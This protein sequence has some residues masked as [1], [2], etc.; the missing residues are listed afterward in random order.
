MQIS[1][2]FLELLGES[3]AAKLDVHILDVLLIKLPDILGISTVDSSHTDKSNHKSCIAG[4]TRTQS[5]KPHGTA[6]N[7]PNSLIA[8]SQPIYRNPEDGNLRAQAEAIIF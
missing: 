4:N 8:R 2:S 1:P 6:R 5:V 7:S 3:F